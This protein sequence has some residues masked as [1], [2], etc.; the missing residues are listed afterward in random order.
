MRIPGRGATSLGG[1]S[2]RTGSTASAMSGSSGRRAGRGKHRLQPGCRGGPAGEKSARRAPPARFLHP[3]EETFPPS[4]VR[5][6][7]TESRLARTAHH[8]VS[9]V[10]PGYGVRAGGVLVVSGKEW[11]MVR[12][13]LAAFAVLGLCMA[14]AR[15]DDQNQKN[16]G[17]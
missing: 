14:G 8:H 12:F 4:H 9:P 17:D 11:V 6:G 10:P 3:P 16:K 5:L 15:A 13:V 2:P 7:A 1:R